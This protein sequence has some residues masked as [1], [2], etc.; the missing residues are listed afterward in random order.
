MHDF[1]QR[2]TFVPTAWRQ[3]GAPPNK[4]EWELWGISLAGDGTDV[5]LGRGASHAD[6]LVQAQAKLAAEYPGRFI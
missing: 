3:T 5:L 6:C 2:G 4:T 1:T